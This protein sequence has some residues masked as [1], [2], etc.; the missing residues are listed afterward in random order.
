MF[1]SNVRSKFL[2]FVGKVSGEK[3]GKVSTRVIGWHNA[4]IYNE[5]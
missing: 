3:S 4:N 2:Y 1:R 5:T